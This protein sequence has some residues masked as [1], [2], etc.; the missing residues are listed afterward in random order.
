MKKF[1]GLICL[2]LS[3]RNKN[4]NDV[5]KISPSNFC[6]INAKDEDL[7]AH[8]GRLSNQI[9][10][11]GSIAIRKEIF[12]GTRMILRNILNLLPATK[13]DPYIG[14]IALQDRTI[15]YIDSFKPL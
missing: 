4:R 8:L 13:S 2:I 7:A 10:C 5:K 1:T 3:Y 9:C 11:W 12:P 6:K 15:L 14:I